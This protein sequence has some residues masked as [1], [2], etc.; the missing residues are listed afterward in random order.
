MLLTKRTF[1]EGI[2]T[3][4]SCGV[5]F[6]GCIVAFLVQPLSQACLMMERCTLRAF[7]STVL[8]LCLGHLTGK[9]R[10]SLDHAGCAPAWVPAGGRTS[11]SF[12]LS[13]AGH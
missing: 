11:F 7:P 6:R 13:E 9:E 8:G 5:R 1:G 3:F 2:L 10:P 12:I 4:L